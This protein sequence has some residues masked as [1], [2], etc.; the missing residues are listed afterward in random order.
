MAGQEE[1]LRLRA[2]ELTEREKKWMEEESRRRR[3]LLNLY[4]AA[5]RQIN[6]KQQ[7]P[8]EQQGGLSGDD[9]EDESN[10]AKLRATSSSTDSITTSEAGSDRYKTKPT[11]QSAWLTY[12][13]ETHH[14]NFHVPSSKSRDHERRTLDVSNSA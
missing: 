3:E 5:N 6:E 9:K 1:V 13:T 12:A 11:I 7:T 10:E 2:V 8:Q 14:S 4:D